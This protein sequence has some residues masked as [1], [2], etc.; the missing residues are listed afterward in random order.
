MFGCCDT[1]HVEV[2]LKKYWRS[3]FVCGSNVILDNYKKGKLRPAEKDKIYEGNTIISP[4]DSDMPGVEP[5][6]HT[7][8]K[9]DIDQRLASVLDSKPQLLRQLSPLADAED[10]YP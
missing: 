5:L 3:N 10:T 8:H 4:F 2:F 6:D 7:P 1:F 9:I